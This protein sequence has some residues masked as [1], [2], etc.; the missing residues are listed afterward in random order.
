MRVGGSGLRYPRTNE[1]AINR[2][3]LQRLNAARADYAQ[4]PTPWKEKRIARLRREF[5]CLH[6]RAQ[7][8]HVN[9]GYGIDWVC[10]NCHQV[11]AYN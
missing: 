5:Y 4:F 7:M 9:G 1:E 8:Q 10:S 11:V 3:L 2:A 6:E